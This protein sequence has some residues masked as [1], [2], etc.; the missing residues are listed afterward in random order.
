MAKPSEPS[1]G[2]KAPGPVKKGTAEHALSKEL[3]LEAAFQGVRDYAVF[4]LDAHGKVT[5]WTAE[6]ERTK[7]YKAS[8]VIGKNHAV[9]YLPEDV[10]AGLP[11]E[12]LQAAERD[13]RHVTEG[14]RLR[15]DGTKMWAEVLT[16]ALRAPDGKLRGF[17]KVVRDATDRV[18]LNAQ[19]QKAAQTSEAQVLAI[20]EVAVDAIITIDRRGRIATFNKAAQKMFG[21]THA[22]VAGKNVTV[23]M[24]QPYKSEHDSYLSNYH[25]TGQ[26]KIIGIG[27]EVAAKK[28]DGTIFPIDLAV[29]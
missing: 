14:W 26:K 2:R 13:G 11:Q 28:K 4:M 19:L 9:F 25:K 18:T 6:A 3:P 22:E 21:Y 23:L 10:A 17:A 15:R 12:A 20:L 8:E 16:A 5:S 24:P 7:G 29:S 27:R 1:P